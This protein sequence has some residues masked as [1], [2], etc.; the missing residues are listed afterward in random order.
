MFRPGNTTIENPPT[1]THTHT[2]PAHAV[3]ERRSNERGGRG[4]VTSCVVPPPHGLPTKRAA[5]P[6]EYDRLL[7]SWRYRGERRHR[8]VSVDLFAFP[9]IMLSCVA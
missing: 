4:G 7:T 8:S 3:P 2:D 9:E 5:L 6:T 1:H